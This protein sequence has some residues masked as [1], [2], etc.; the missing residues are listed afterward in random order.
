MT[1]STRC[2]KIG[3]LVV[4]ER[5]IHG[6]T[7]RHEKLPTRV[8]CRAGS[9]LTYG[10]YK[11]PI[12]VCSDLLLERCN[13][14]LCFRLEKYFITFRADCQSPC[15]HVVQSIIA[16]CNN[17][18]YQHNIILAR[19]KHIAKIVSLIVIRHVS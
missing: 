5:G 17:H 12:A 18:N 3:I 6:C 11:V 19:R 7:Y 4:C 1:K 16:I 8:H 9:H 13:G 2:P 15:A 10:T 14:R